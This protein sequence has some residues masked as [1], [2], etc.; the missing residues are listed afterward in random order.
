MASPDHTASIL[1]VGAGILSC[2][3]PT[4]MLNYIASCIN[5]L[6]GEQLVASTDK[7]IIACYVIYNHSY[8]VS[9]CQRDPRARY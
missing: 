7:T 4:N 6:T 9:A 5:P 2:C 1:Y 8:T 3:T